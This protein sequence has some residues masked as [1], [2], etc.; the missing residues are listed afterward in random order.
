MRVVGG[1]YREICQ[2][3]AWD[4]LFGS[5][6]R[7]AIAV[8]RL[9]PEINLTTYCAA[10]W[11]QDIEVTAATFGIGLTAHQQL[12]GITFRYFH[13][14]SGAVIEPA[15]IV[16]SQPLMVSDDVVLRFGMIEGDAIVQA[17]TAIYDPQTGGVPARFRDNGSRA[18]RL[19]IVLNDFE[20]RMATGLAPL[21]AVEHLQKSENAEVVVVKMGPRGALVQVRGGK[22]ERIPPV[23][24]NKVFKIGSG[25]VFS[26]VFAHYWGEAG[27]HPVE[28]ATLASRSVAHFVQGH[29]L[30]IPAPD[31]LITGDPITLRDRAGQIYLAGP[32][33]TIAQRWLIEE[34]RAALW[35]MDIPVFS[36]L[37]DVG[38]TGRTHDIAAADL[39][40]L[41][42]CVA[43]LALI[44][45]LDP[46]TLF[47]V[48]Y[49]RK[50]G[51]SVVAL[52]ERV[53]ESNLTMFAGTDCI[54]ES[55]FTTA[56]YK[57]SFQALSI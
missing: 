38:L 46:G 2:Y 13:P 49:A 19:A 21:E 4:R 12:S 47:E 10:K 24:S 18:D 39:R 53:N 26:A 32:F 6:L 11:A 51:I 52:A 48:G 56:I 27:L 54:V 45:G 44:D 23:F 20:A 35:A 7:A 3:P 31:G 14:L 57:T 5:G 33:F 42:G 8:S 36:P 9:S 1:A 55:D 40:G 29:Q 34:A 30:P 50:A 25:D 43:M 28:A 22:P 16:Q 41:E 15:A 37:H 17:R